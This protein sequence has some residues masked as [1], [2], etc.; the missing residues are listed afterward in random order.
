[1]SKA[2]DVCT[3]CLQEMFRRVG[4]TYPMPELTDHDDWYM[5]HSWTEEEEN[6]FRA[7][8]D[9]HLKRRMRWN[10]RTRAKEIAFFLLQWGWTTNEAKGAR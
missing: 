10:K 9:K 2:S 8:M 3:E 6:D 4:L 7:W 1:M 5:Q